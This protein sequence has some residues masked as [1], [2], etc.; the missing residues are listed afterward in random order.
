MKSPSA[1]ELAGQL[2]LIAI[3]AV[4][5]S[6]L[7]SALQALPCSHPDAGHDCYPWGTES[8]G[9][10]WYYRSKAHYLISA[11]IQLI[12]IAVAIVAPLKASNRKTGLLSLIAFAISGTLIVQA[13]GL[14]F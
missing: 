12:A 5:I 11:L 9:A 8:A 10:F 14:F 6:D 4:L 7:I 2:I 3:G 13:A 1:I